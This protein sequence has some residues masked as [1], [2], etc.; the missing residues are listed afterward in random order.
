MLESAP[1]PLVPVTVAEGYAALDHAH[2]H[3]IA[4]EIAEVIAIAHL[5]DVYRID[6]DAVQVGMEDLIQPGADG[7][8]S[9]GEFLSLEI[10]AL[11]G[12]SPLSAMGRIADVLNVRHR[13]PALWEAV[14]AGRVRWWQ[15]ADAAGRAQHL[16]AAAVALLDRKLAHALAL[17]PWARVLRNLDGWI[18][19]ADPQTAADAEARHRTERKVV[20]NQIR[21]GHIEIWGRLAP[22]DALAFDQ[23]INEIAK[24]MP[25]HLDPAHPLLADLSTEALA[26][27]DLQTR[28]AAAVGELARRTFGQDILPT[29]QLFVHITGS[30]PWLTGD[31]TPG[32]ELLPD[33]S[34]TGIARVDR[35]GCLPTDRLRELLADSRVIVRPVLDPNSIPA[36]DHYN[37]TGLM[38]LAME[39]RN[40]VDVFP[41]GTRIAR[42]CDAD[43][44]RPFVD[45]GPRGQTSPDNLGPLCRFTHRAKTHGGW[46]LTQPEP[47]QFHWRSPAGYEYL[48][49]S[50]GTTRISAPRPARGP[51]PPVLLR[52]DDPPRDDP[53]WDLLPDRT[54]PLSLLTLAT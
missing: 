37:P 5:M 2:R 50:Q 31:P 10:G 26:K 23:A 42:G 7:T 52:G 49:T 33:G 11:L 19:A 4:A 8:P 24:A 45:G 32:L 9:I 39:V 21:D 29:H 3:L 14:L 41:F 15:A 16:S 46:R 12:L 30:D 36:V 43:H 53:A 54:P 22:A 48:V 35:W 38:R 17:M 51:A 13:H 44:T 28:R 47:G 27:A 6:D 18:L 34:A 20:L 1:A 40:P 25:A